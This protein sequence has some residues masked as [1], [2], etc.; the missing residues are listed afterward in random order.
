MG[1]DEVAGFDA[2]PYAQDAVRLRRWDDE[3]KE[4]D[5]VVPAFED[6]TALLYQLI[7]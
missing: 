2:E 5:R 3:A 7:R 4:P 1:P 6:Y